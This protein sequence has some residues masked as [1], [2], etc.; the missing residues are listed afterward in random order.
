M[1][2]HEEFEKD[3]L[4]YDRATGP[5]L[6]PQKVALVPAAARLPER[7]HARTSKPLGLSRRARGRLS[8]RYTA[9]RSVDWLVDFVLEKARPGRI[10]SAAYARPA[11]SARPAQQRP[12]LPRVVSPVGE[13]VRGRDAVRAGRKDGGLRRRR[14]ASSNGINNVL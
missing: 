9:V 13:G 7:G 6:A 8:V 1:R 3:L 14:R 11:G 5:D 12:G 4:A 10:V 2:R